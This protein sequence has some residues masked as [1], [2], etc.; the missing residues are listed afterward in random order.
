M[1]FKKRFALIN[2]AHRIAC[3][4]NIIVEY[5]KSSTNYFPT[6]METFHP[7]NYS[8]DDSNHLAVVTTAGDILESIDFGSDFR[9][10]MNYGKPRTTPK[11]V[12]KIEGRRNLF[13]HRMK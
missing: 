13:Q 2:R 4:Q 9:R 1:S 7:S 6:S 10:A 11:T 3:S 5:A 12:G 8:P